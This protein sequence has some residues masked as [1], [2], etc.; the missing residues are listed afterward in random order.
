MVGKRVTHLPKNSRVRHRQVTPPDSAYEGRR[1]IACPLIN[2]KP[3]LNSEKES[4]N[5]ILGIL[6]KNGSCPFLSL[7]PWERN[8]QYAKAVVF[9]TASNWLDLSEK[10]IIIIIFKSQI[11]KQREVAVKK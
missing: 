9:P 1:E 2:S 8:P 10:D 5:S 7:E 11:L 3:S 6:S 4:K